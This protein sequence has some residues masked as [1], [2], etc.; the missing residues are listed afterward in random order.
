MNALII[1]RRVWK[2][3]IIIWE[4][5]R[6]LISGRRYVLL[7]GRKY[8]LISE[9]RYILIRGRMPIR[10]NHGGQVR[11]MSGCR[12]A[13]ISGRRYALISGRTYVLIS[14][15]RYTYSVNESKCGNQQNIEWRCSHYMSCTRRV[16]LTPGEGRFRVKKRHGRFHRSRVHRNI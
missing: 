4:G 3:T 12:Y 1:S 7:S 13:L 2:V 5:R 14:G 8:L 11:I 15:R 16:H 6:V 10:T 9:L